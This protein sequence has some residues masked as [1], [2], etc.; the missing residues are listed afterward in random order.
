MLTAGNPSCA[1]LGYDYGLK[2]G[3]GA[4]EDTPGTFTDGGLSVTWS[5]TNG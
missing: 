3:A 2:P 1:Q 5:F 4:S